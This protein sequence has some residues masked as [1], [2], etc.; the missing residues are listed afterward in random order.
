MGIPFTSGGLTS[1]MASRDSCMGDKT[2]DWP[3]FERV[4]QNL[5]KNSYLLQDEDLKTLSQH[6]TSDLINIRSDLKSKLDQ[7]GEEL[8]EIILKAA[9]E[10][11]PKKKTGAKPKPWWTTEL[12][13]FRKKMLKSQRTLF[14]DPGNTNSKKQY[15]NSRNKYFQEIKT[16]K[17]NH[18]NAFLEKENPSAIFKAL[19]Y[20]KE[21]QS[22][23]LPKI[24][25]EDNELK[26]NF[27]EKCQALKAKLF[28]T[29]PASTSFNWDHHK[30][31]NWEWP[32]LTQIEV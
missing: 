5:F 3:K 26:S 1:Y 12:K 22:N 8:T 29:P 21:K 24:K 20:T 2:W 10:S 23:K 16:A 4:S 6:T 31:T 18:W 19:S 9:E 32:T 28:P 14:K 11:I 27:S 30:E 17:K 7:V 15:L 25:G 13:G